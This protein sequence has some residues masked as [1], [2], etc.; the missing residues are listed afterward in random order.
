[1]CRGQITSTVAFAVEGQDSV[2]PQ[3]DLPAPDPARRVHA[4]EGEG[5]VGHGVDQV[6]AEVA[7]T[8][9]QLPVVASKGPYAGFSGTAGER[10]PAAGASSTP[11]SVLGWRLISRRPV[12][13]S[14]PP[15]RTST[16]YRAA[17]WL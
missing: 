16:A 6:P 14:P 9:P 8:R 5:W 4:Q 3:P 15:L 1:I 2:R 11:R 17:T 7:G 10:S 13:I 12:C